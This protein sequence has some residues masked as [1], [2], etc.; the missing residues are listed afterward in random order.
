MPEPS[1]AELQRLGR[2]HI[3]TPHTQLNDL[4]DPDYLG[5]IVGGQGSY[6]YDSNGK[7]YLDATS[8]SHCTLVG[9]ARQEIAAAVYKQMSAVEFAGSGMIP[10]STPP[11]VKLAAK[12][13][14]LSPG[15]L[16]RT[17][18]TTSGTESVEAALKM[19]RQYHAQTGN[20]QKYKVLY[21]DFSFHGFTWG[22]MAVS[23]DPVIR[24]P[25][26]EPMHP[27]GV[28]VPEAN[29]SRCQFCADQC[30][31]GCARAIEDTV[32]YHGP[33]SI[34]AFIVEPVEKGAVAQPPEYWRIV[35]DLCRKHNILIIA[36]EVVTAFG[37]TGK[38]FGSLHASL[39]TDIMVFGKTLGG[40]YLP[41]GAVLTSPKVQDGFRGDRSKNLRHSPTLAAHPASTIAA[42]TNLEIVE[43][44]GLVE[45]AEKMGY[46]LRDGL[47]ALR[48]YSVVADVRSIGM[49]AAVDLGK[50]GDVHQ[51]LGLELGKKMS[52]FMLDNGLFMV[53]RGANFSIHPPLTI[54]ESELDQVLD[55][56]DRTL[57]FAEENL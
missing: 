2:K 32:R 54:S 6:V 25:M 8:M 19:A 12:L 5:I 42:L 48:R 13:A 29:P 36:D 3:W 1:F 46:R 7:A 57:A 40:G 26:F 24:S 15:D 39:E 16:D 35:Q 14:E 52:R 27:M 22:A 38:W 53:T 11:T 30:N 9:H 41:I 47:H 49:L 21:R 33:D 17:L 28:M 20:P 44:E 56:L 37:R 31:L 55:I 4:D 51:P 43:R 18:F 10:F 23:G 34:A 50:D 45:R